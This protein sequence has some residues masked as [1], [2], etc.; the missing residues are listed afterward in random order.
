MSHF[1]YDFET[2]ES[3]TK[4]MVDSLKRMYEGMSAKKVSPNVEPGFL[5][6]QLSENPS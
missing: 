3:G 4:D 6:S 1:F 2:L 5:R